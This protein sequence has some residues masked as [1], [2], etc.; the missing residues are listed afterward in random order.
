[1]AHP[2]LPFCHVQNGGVGPSGR[3]KEGIGFGPDKLI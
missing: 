2:T 3:A 1:M